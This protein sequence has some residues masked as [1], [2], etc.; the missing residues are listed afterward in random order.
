MAVFQFAQADNFGK[1]AA[2]ITVIA[3]IGVFVARRWIAQRE[4]SDGASVARVLLG[5]SLVAIAA[6]LIAAIIGPHPS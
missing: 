6:A 2:A 3:L 4:E 5:A 1:A